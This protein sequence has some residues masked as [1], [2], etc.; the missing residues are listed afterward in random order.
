MTV[1]GR[2]LGE[3]LDALAKDGFFRRN[4]GYL[5]NYRLTVDDLFHRI[6]PWDRWRCCGG[7]IA[8]DGAVIKYAA[9]DP[10]MHVHTGPARVFDCEEDCYLAV[11]EKR[12]RP[13][14]VL[15]IRYEGPRGS[16]MPEMLMTTEAIMCDPDISGSVALITDGRFSGGTRGPCIGH[17]S[18]EAAVGGPLA[19]LEDGDLIA[20]D[21][22][23]PDI[24]YG[25]RSRSFAAPRGGHRAAHGRAP[26]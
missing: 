4:V 19:L 10:A 26:P 23:R 21:I 14:D 15:I 22:P 12:I 6:R 11:V 1:T 25:G 18:P 8:P 20:I 3:N 5:M 16:G 13:G 7:N 9:A 2:T 17:L 24:K